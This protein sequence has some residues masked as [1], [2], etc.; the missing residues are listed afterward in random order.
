MGGGGLLHSSLPL[1]GSL[2]MQRRQC[3]VLQVPLWPQGIIGEGVVGNMFLL[4]LESS[5]TWSWFLYDTEQ[6]KKFFLIIEK[7]SLFP[8]NLP[9]RRSEL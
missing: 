5:L 7:T 3:I 6:V 4:T 8:I 9:C 1:A 2:T